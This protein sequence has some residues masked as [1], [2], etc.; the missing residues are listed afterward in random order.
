ME[1]IQGRGESYPSEKETVATIMKPS[2]ITYKMSIPKLI[3]YLRVGM[4]MPDKVSHENTTDINW[5]KMAFTSERRNNSLIA[6]SRLYNFRP[7]N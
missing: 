5:R 3:K 1:G 2:T 6:G 7:H 4:F